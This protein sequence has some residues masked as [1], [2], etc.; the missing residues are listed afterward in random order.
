MKCKEC[1][2]E[3]LE[4]DCICGTCGAEVNVSF[5][6]PTNDFVSPASNEPAYQSL[7]PT[8]EEAEL[9]RRQRRQEAPYI[10]SSGISK[11]FNSPLLRILE[12]II[13][14]ISVV[15][16]LYCFNQN[17]FNIDVRYNGFI[18]DLSS[19]S[20]VKVNQ[21]T[22]TILSRSFTVHFAKLMLALS[23][24]TILILFVKKT[25]KWVSLTISL[26]LI[27]TFY[28]IRSASK[29]L[30]NAKQTL[31]SFIKQYDFEKYGMH[32]RLGEGTGYKLLILIAVLLSLSLI[33]QLLRFITKSYKSYT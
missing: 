20:N 16:T 30:K 26:Q 10:S 17:C 29:I 18:T 24:I 22:Y 31:P 23:I 1:G 21:L 13:I 11:F 14:V 32:I 8:Y 15:L 6:N 7:Y 5:Q 9:L 27:S 25:N 33:M 2:A 4:G 3:L 12:K 28:C 19:V